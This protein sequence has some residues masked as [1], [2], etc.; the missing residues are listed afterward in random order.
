MSRYALI[1]EDDVFMPFT[2]D[3]PMLVQSAP[4][5]FGILQ[6]FN[7]EVS[8][9]N[10]SWNSYMSHIA[11]TNAS[12][13]IYREMGANFYSAGAYLIDRQQLKPI[14][15]KVVDIAKDGKISLSIIAGSL[16]GIRPT[17]WR[18]EESSDAQKLQLRLHSSHHSTSSSGTG[19]GSE[20]DKKHK[21]KPKNTQNEVTEKG[22]VHAKSNKEMHVKNGSI[23]SIGN[24]GKRDADKREHERESRRRSLYWYNPR[25]A[26]FPK[27][28]CSPNG[29]KSEDVS[30]CS[31]VVD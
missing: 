13:W 9:I 17:E 1:L 12:P 3:W 29:N 8:L 11:E 18:N 27:A 19:T 23:S 24:T 25:G 4:K 31:L 5:D 10:S 7:S 16:N 22:K 6:L 26:C 15:E 30:K 28:C 20:H 2:I 21:H 14:I